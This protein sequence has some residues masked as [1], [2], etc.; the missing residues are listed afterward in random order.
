MRGGWREEQMN[1]REPVGK[2]VKVCVSVRRMV[3]STDVDRSNV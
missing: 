1:G 2:V 3:R